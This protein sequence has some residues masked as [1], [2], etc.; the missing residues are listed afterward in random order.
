MSVSQ[1]KIKMTQSSLFYRQEFVPFFCYCFASK[2]QNFERKW[3]CLCVTIAKFH[4]CYKLMSM[5]QNKIKMAQSSLLYRQ[6]FV[7]TYTLF[8][9]KKQ[10]WR[11]AVN[12]FSSRRVWVN[13]TADL[14]CASLNLQ[15]SVCN[16]ASNFFF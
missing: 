15:F 14:A 4:F 5:S 9:Q 8:V 7:A 16:P 11:K 1:N 3:M 2:W 6:E 12:Q 13:V 10:S